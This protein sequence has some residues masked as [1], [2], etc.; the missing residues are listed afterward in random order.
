MGV[1]ASLFVDS[2]A[3]WHVA[4]VDAS[5]RV[6]RYLEVAN[7]STVGKAEVVDDGL[8]VDGV[9]FDD[10]W[11]AVG[12]DANIVVTDSGEVRIAYQDATAGTLRYAVG[13]PQSGGGHTWSIKVVDDGNTTGFFPKLLTVGGETKIA[14]W[15][16]AG[17]AKI[18]GNVRLVAP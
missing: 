6:L 13:T 8:G 3:S 1:G 9:P 17:G 7:G 15:W 18:E 11:H 10:A 4:Y 2:A 14:T 16:R 5:Q 12:E